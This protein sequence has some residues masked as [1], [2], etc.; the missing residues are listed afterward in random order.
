MKPQLCIVC[1]TNPKRKNRRTCSRSCAMKL[2][3][4]EMEARGVAWKLPSP[5]HKWNKDDLPDQWGEKNTNWRGGRRRPKSGYIEVICPIG[6]PKA[7]AHKYMMEHRLI[8]EKH[9][10]RYL[11]PWEIVHHKNGIK[12][13]NR[14]ENLELL[15]KKTHRGKV[16]CPYCKR[17]FSIL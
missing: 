6:H 3:I 17:E 1:Q 13:D 12:D 9:L 8:M 5:A 7:T 11:E 15:T 14:I 10:K 2:T 16:V 4:R